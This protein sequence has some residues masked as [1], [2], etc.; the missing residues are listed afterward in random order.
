VSG[1]REPER[2]DRTAECPPLRVHRIH[3]ALRLDLHAEGVARIGH[4]I[5]FLVLTW[6]PTMSVHILEIAIPDLFR[7]FPTETP[8][9]RLEQGG[10]ETSGRESEGG[11]STMGEAL[12]DVTNQPLANR[13]LDG[14]TAGI[15]RSTETFPILLPDGFAIR[16]R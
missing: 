5:L 4:Q 9:L 8:L 13:L 15:N 6:N 7:L 16:Q 10:Y 3:A 2:T 1:T 11:L 12:A 14:S